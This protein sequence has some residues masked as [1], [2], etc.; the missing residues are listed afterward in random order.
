M[1]SA[2]INLPPLPAQPRLSVVVPIFNE[3]STASAALD[4][5]T[6]KRIKGWDIE[7][8]IVESNSTDGT[9]ELVMPYATELAFNWCL[10]KSLAAKATLSAMVSPIPPVT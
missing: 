10:K 2:P 3:C 1:S 6:S 5:I 8:I 7:V 4:A 9:K